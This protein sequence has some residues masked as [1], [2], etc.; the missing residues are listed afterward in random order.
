VVVAALPAAAVA[1]PAGLGAPRVRDV[2]IRVDAAPD[3]RLDLESLTELAPGAALTEDAVRRTL[4]NLYATGWVDEAEVFTRPASPPPDG[5]A[6]ASW[7]TAVVVVRGRL[8]VDSVELAGE[9]GIRERELRRVLEQSPQTALSDEK[10][11]RGHHALQELYAERGYRE[12]VV[13]LVVAE[14]A[15]AKQVDVRYEVA[16]GPRARVAGVHFEGDL[17]GLAEDDLRGVLRSRSGSFYDHR[18]IEE[19]RERLRAWLRRRDFSSARVEPPRASYDPAAAA[20]ELR[21]PIDV[22]PRIEVEVAGASRRRLEKRGLL[23][24]LREADFDRQLT[25]QSC[26]RIESFFQGKGHYEAL[27][28]CELEE[29]E[30]RRKVTIEVEPGRRFEL[31][32]IRFEG[33]REIASEELERL[34]STTV[35]RPL[36]PGSG[37]L[38]TADLLEDLANLRS[39]YLLH[40][41]TEIEVGPSVIVERGDKL[42]LRIPVD[43]GRRQRLVEL[44]LAGNRHFTRDELLAKL[45]LKPG[46]AFHPVLLEDSLNVLRALYEEQGYLSATVA[47]HLD[48]NDDHTLVDVHL[49]IREAAQ[50]RVDRIILRGYR[51]SRPE[52]LRDFL[53]LEEGDPIS[54]RKLLE[55]ERDLYRLG[56]FSRVDVEAA[57]R[58]ESA[59][60]RD[61]IVRLE[62]GKLWRLAYGLSYHSDDGIGGLFG[63][64]R[65]NVG[66]RG[67]RFQLDLRG[68][69]LDRRFRMLYDRPSFLGGK[70]PITFSLF[71]QQEDR[72]SFTVRD[73]GAQVSLIKDFRRLRAG[74][75]Y[76]YRLVD[77][78]EETVDPSE[79]ERE[80]R[81]LEIS[82][83]TPNLFLDRR[84]DPLDPNRGWSTSLQLELAFP[85]LSAETDFLKLF[86]QQTVY[87]PLGRAGLLAGSVRLGAIEPGGGSLPDSTVPEGLP[88]ALVPVSERFF[89]GGRTSHRAFERDQLGVV[90]E[91]LLERDNGDFLELGGNGLFIVNLDYRFPVAGPLGG[92]L[93]LDAGN[94]WADWRDFDASEIELGAGLGVRYLSPIGPIR[95]EIGWKIE[96]DLPDADK[97]VFFFSFGNPF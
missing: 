82:S 79:V 4:S 25:A 16:S 90:G 8:W 69:G 27:A 67:D 55:A 92:T 49:E 74:L 53:R 23:P 31:T 50:T 51:H 33:N 97:P 12:A 64:T 96:S 84:D 5:G 19:D 22:G 35:R 75:V 58:L 77:L 3:K 87:Q 71:Q 10:L 9:L 93:F 54:R 20:I 32:E 57:P 59:E 72:T 30:G 48:W 46:G 66:G 26:S 11:L 83:L 29:Q 65:S 40:G 18:R 88:S 86:W 70:V 76:E 63:V 81:E 95:L 21:F 37:R 44:T 45:P 56:I 15:A 80:N 2:E 14:S 62:E 73:L 41:F 17:A 24:F 89:G 94:V 42:E 38:V 61:V 1:D 6:T 52:V 60:R 91:T 47:P 36:R 7:V 34:L 39:Y 43:E 13:T 28:E 68:S 85:F 78:S